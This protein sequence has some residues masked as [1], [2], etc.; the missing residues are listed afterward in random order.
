M[1]A[2]GIS[3]HRPFDDDYR[4]FMHLI[5]NHVS[6][7]ISNGR[8]YEVEKERAEILAQLDADKDAF[9]SNVSHDFRTP[10]TLMLVC[11]DMYELCKFTVVQGP[12]DDVL[13]D[14][15]LSQ[16]SH[17]KLTIAQRNGHR[18]LK[19]VNDLLDFSKVEAGKASFMFS[20]IGIPCCFV[21]VVNNVDLPQIL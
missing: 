21:A 16:S 6:S 1:L 8:A 5:A 14:P 17:T 9:F 10:L 4:Q 19:L 2:I 15:Q 11:T 20:P 7:A 3:K 13:H 18:L 12:I